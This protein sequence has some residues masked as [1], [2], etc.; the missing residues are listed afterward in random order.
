[1]SKRPSRPLRQTVDLSGYPD[2]V[3]IYPGT[4]ANSLRGLGTVL[5]FG[6]R[7]TVSVRAR[8]NGLHVHETLFYSL[9]PLH[10]GIRQ[11]WRDFDALE[12]WARTL[13][14]QHW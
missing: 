10:T 11:Y 12:L 3:V 1:M 5:R 14:H 6:P 9:F 7:I 4:R 8:P 2:L 13:S